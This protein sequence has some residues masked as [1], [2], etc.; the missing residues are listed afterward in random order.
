MFKIKDI[1][2]QAGK[3]NLNVDLSDEG[4]ERFVDRA[5]HKSR[6]RRSFSRSAA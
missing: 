2:N 3:K 1:L 5:I 4:V 6:R